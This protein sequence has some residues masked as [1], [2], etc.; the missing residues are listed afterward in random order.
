MHNGSPFSGC[1][2]EEVTFGSEV[3]T[4]PSG[5][6]YDR[7]QLSDIRFSGKTIY[8]GK[9]AF[10]GTFW[11]G[12]LP[13]GMVYI[14]HVA[15]SYKGA[16]A[17]PTAISIVE[18]TQSVTDGLLAEQTYLTKVTVPSTLAY[19]GREVFE[20]CSSLG[21]VEW[22]A[23]DCDLADAP[24]SSTSLYAIT[25]GSSV[26]KVPSML[27]SGCRFLEAVS[28]PQ[29]VTEIGSSAFS[30]CSGLMEVNFSA[31]LDS[32]GSSAFSGCS[33]LESVVLPEGLRSVAD[34]TFQDCEKLSSVDLPDS[35]RYIGNEAFLNHALQALVIP[36]KVE[37]IGER[38]FYQ[39]SWHE[40]TLRS[41][42]YNAE[43][44][45]ID[46]CS[47]GST[48][49]ES[50]L[51]LEI[52]DK[53]RYVPNNLADGLVNLTTLKVGRGVQSMEQD[54]FSGCRQLVAVEW[55]AVNLDDA[56]TPFPK[57][58]AQMT[59]GEDV[60]RIPS[61]LCSELENLV[62]VSLPASLKTIG[63]DAFAESGLSSIEIP[64]NVT[65]MEE[66]A[67]RHCTSLA[68]VEI[69]KNL[70]EIPAYAFARCGALTDIRI[71]ETVAG[72]GYSAFGDCTSLTSVEIPDGVASIGAWAFSGCSQ[73]A[74]VRIGKALT[75]MEEY[76]FEDCTAL[77]SVQ[78]DAVDFQ[79]QCRFPSTL[80]DVAF[81]PEVE[82]VPYGICSSC[83]QLAHVEF[84]ASVKS[85]GDYA[86]SGCTGL[87]DIPL[88]EGLQS[89]GRFAFENCTGITSVDFPSSLSLVN[90]GAFHGCGLQSLFIPSTLISFGDNAF[91]YNVSLAQVI[92]AG[93]PF[94]IPSNLFSSC[95]NALSIYVGD[96]NGFFST[97]GWWGYMSQLHPMVTFEAEEY[98]YTGKEPS[99]KHVV[100]LPGC[101]VADMAVGEPLPV[102]AGY[103]EVPLQF[104]FSGP[105]TF[106][107]AVPHQFS[108]TPRELTVAVEDAER[109][110]GAENPEFSLVYDGFVEGEDVS[111]LDELPVVSCDAGTWSGVGEYDIYLYGGSAK[112]YTFSYENGTL[113]VTQASQVITWEQALDNLKVGD[114]VVLEA[115]ASS[116]NPVVFILDETDAA[117]L[118]WDDEAY[119]YVL[120]CKA[121]GEITLT[122]I[123]NGGW[124]YKPA[125]PVVKTVSIAKG[126]GVESLRQD[127]RNGKA[128][129]ESGRIVVEGIPAGVDVRVYAP[130]GLL[131]YVGQSDGGRMDIPVSR[132]GLCIVK[133]PGRTVKLMAGTVL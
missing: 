70:K 35:L 113:L 66:R 45:E 112:N 28:F 96:T 14:D 84:P 110:Y 72:I 11:L 74:S 102:D 6:F 91:G 122:A 46:G 44:C 130:D 81:G 108:I 7:G 88:P 111:V 37:Y 17:T 4:I 19:M 97:G 114:E 40:C 18:G 12:S 31:T 129:V 69:G 71:P 8:V 85:I 41:L 33:L 36:E 118:E 90:N 3:D 127:G 15:Y 103:Y 53:V 93:E 13:Q 60:E 64:D 116:Y 57:S 106:T 80:T 124:N 86:F 16:M 115:A 131:L 22:N 123:Q 107:V 101:T 121:E 104:T 65:T 99:P 79:G 119:A 78:W 82:R 20:G 9:D 67:F 62:S 68:S 94:E 50:L 29:N 10:H 47:Y 98:V 133:W 52:G 23:E 77:T 39:D 109:E 125:E 56:R 21:E 61:N 51:S 34:D 32:I 55:N 2:V 63:Y 48:F 5:L 25:F 120:T 128:Y 76:A 26:R 105:E 38:A 24:F 132:K 95:G 27:C 42:V 117:I 126:T 43:N 59:F 89:I 92:V 73:L 49:S 58:V 30:G 83:A 100:N 1:P 75:A 54:C 87:Q